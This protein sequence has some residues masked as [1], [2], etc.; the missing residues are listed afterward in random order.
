[1]TK[2]TVTIKRQPRAFIRVVEVSL[3]EEEVIDEGA[4]PHNQLLRRIEAIA[5]ILDVGLEEAERIVLG[6]E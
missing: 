1:M 4:D 2:R 3:F 5:S 6:R